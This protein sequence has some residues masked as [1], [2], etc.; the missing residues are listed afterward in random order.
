MFSNG[1][2]GRAVI[3]SFAVC[4]FSWSKAACFSLGTF[5]T[6]TLKN[7]VSAVPVYSG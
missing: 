5:W 7:E 6:G 1:V 2:C 4:V 3:L